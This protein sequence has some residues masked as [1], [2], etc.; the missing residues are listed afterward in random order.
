MILEVYP[1]ESSTNVITFS[2]WRSTTHEESQR[3]RFRSRTRPLPYQNIFLFYWRKHMSTISPEGN[4]DV[5]EDGICLPR[6]VFSFLPWNARVAFIG[7]LNHRHINNWHSFTDCIKKAAA[8]HF[9]L[10]F[11]V[12]QQKGVR[13]VQ[14]RKQNTTVEFYRRHSILFI[15]KNIGQKS[16]LTPVLGTS[17]QRTSTV[18]FSTPSSQRQS[19]SVDFYRFI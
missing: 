15:S 8:K 18:S 4:N 13:D 11:G 1:W 3:T 19:R 16:N 9:G 17:Y 5:V 10:T 6:S 2:T 14:R 12:S 7:E